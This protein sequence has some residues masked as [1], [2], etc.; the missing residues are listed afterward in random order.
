MT[1]LRSLVDC[2]AEPI[3]LIIHEDGTLAET[4]REK[5]RT[6]AFNVQFIDRGH[7][8]SVVQPRL[9]RHPR[10]LATRASGPLFLKLFD[11]ALMADASLL[12]CDSDVLFL[13]KYTGIF[14]PPARGYAYMADTANA[15]SVRPWRVWPAGSIRLGR[16]VNTGIIAG[17]AGLDLDHVEW[18]LGRLAGDSAF[19]RRPYWAEQTCWAAIAARRGFQLFRPDRVILASASMAGVTGNT[20]AIHFVSTFRNRLAA[21]VDRPTP[22]PKPAIEVEKTPGREITAVGLLW[23]DLRRRV[24]PQAV[25]T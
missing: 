12:Y 19:S 7:A 21:F 3:R 11:I 18:V 25:H 8:D 4:Q 10:C 14:Q 9:E 17:P 22:T 13:R 16:Q 20:V 15:Y 6:L 23:T 2:S 24:L 5:L 1:C